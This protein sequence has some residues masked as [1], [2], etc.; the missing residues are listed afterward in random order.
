MLSGIQPSGGLTLGNYLR[1]FVGGTA[2]LSPYTQIPHAE[3][4]PA[5]PAIA[6]FRVDSLGSF[7]FR[8]F[9]HDL[10]IN[11]LTTTIEPNPK[12]PA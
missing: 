7:D 5:E 9:G 4:P 12:A 2:I 8:N 3:A 10:P 1:A 6:G 11:H